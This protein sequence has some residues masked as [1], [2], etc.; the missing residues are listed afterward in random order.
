MGRHLVFI[1]VSVL[2]AI[3]LQLSG[4]IPAFL[5]ATSNFEMLN[6]FF[7]GVFFVSIFTA[8]PA[9]VVLADL[10]NTMPPLLLALCGGLGNFC[11]DALLYYVFRT[12]VEPDAAAVI[13]HTHFKRIYLSLQKNAFLHWLSVLAGAILI[14]SPFPDEFGIALMGASKISRP[15]FLL[16]VLPLDILCILFIALAVQAF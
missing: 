6:A 14:A 15:V 2:A 9:G 16:M 13:K 11:G 5:E 12:R 1:V 10:S 8:A 3:G 7:A 4:A